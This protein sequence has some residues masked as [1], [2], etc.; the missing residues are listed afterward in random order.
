MEQDRWQ[1]IKRLYEAARELQAGERTGFLEQEC[2]SDKEL[3][4]EIESLLTHRAEPGGFL[5]KPAF[6]AAA[7]MLAE[8]RTGGFLQSTEIRQSPS[9]QCARLSTGSAPWVPRSCG[10]TFSLSLPTHWQWTASARQ[11]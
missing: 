7:R 4:R 1:Q 5:E 6:D 3:R 9:R 8:D 11:G 10:L 2:G